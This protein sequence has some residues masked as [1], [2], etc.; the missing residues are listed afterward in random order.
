MR[1]PSTAYRTPTS[2][3]N[4]RRAEYEVSSGQRV[5]KH[6]LGQYQISRSKRRACYLAVAWPRSVPVI[7]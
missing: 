4:M 5:A 7:G 1:S 3:N 2:Q 6:S